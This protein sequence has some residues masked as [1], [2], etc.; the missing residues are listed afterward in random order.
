[1]GEHEAAKKLMH[2]IEQVTA[3][4]ALHTDDLGGHATTEQVTQAVCALMV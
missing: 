3:N 4:S 2:A 1:L